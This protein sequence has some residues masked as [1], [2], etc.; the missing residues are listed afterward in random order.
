METLDGNFKEALKD[1]KIL[2]DFELGA[3]DQKLKTSLRRRY[4][5]EKEVIRRKLGGLEEIR[6]ELGLSRRKVCQLLLVDPSAWTRWLRNEDKVP[7]HVYRSFQ[8]Y[9]ALIEKHPEWHPQNSFLKSTP[10]DNREVLNEVSRLKS[11]VTKKDEKIN[12]LTVSLEGLSREH[13]KLSGQML[14]SQS[15]QLSWKMIVLINLALA[16]YLL[17]F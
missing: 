4:E 3:S 14:Q 13:K 16:L 10:Q 1:Q 12:Q 5:A 9:F 7:P 11:E 15:I 6:Q 2:A 17:I 8:W